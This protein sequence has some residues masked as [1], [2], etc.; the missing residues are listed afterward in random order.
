MTSLF[1]TLKLGDLELKNRVIMAP[2][3]RMRSGQPGNIPH[4][5]NAEYY[6]QRASA[7]LI[8]SEATQISQQG[9]G[10]PATPGIH[11]PEQVAGWKLV[12]DAVHKAGGKIFLQLWHV[13]RISHSSHQPN[14]GVPV[15][16][17]AI[18]PSGMVFTADWK[19]L[20]YEPP[21]A[22][23]NSELAG[24][25]ADYKKAAQNAKDAGFDGVEVHGANGY[26][27][28]QFLQ[29]GS[30]QRSDNYGGSIE[31]RARLLLEV[32][33]AV[34]EVWGKGRVGVR[35]SPYGTFN[36]M[37]DGDPIALFT[38][39]LEQ[40]SAR[41]IGYAH[42]IEP[43]STSAGGN[44]AVLEEAPS[45]SALFRKSFKGVFLSAGGYTRENALEVVEK[46]EADAVVFGRLFISNPDLP[47]RLKANLPLNRYDRATFYGGA[48]KGYTD[49]PFAAEKAA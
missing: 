6:A 8:I 42:L 4:A 17:S 10:Y 18:T 23:E 20:P 9:Q 21:R 16:P 46:G 37:S 38:Y 43:R 35:L 45:T 28:D 26:L 29:D 27:L 49:Y 13:G 22:L 7:G 48:E 2:L 32:T 31:N 1:D 11:S 24:I 19:Q 47:E 30:N 39:V 34:A 36:D 3:T 5:L 33:D 41:Q 15:A 44:D 14:G 25:V 40:L 12:T